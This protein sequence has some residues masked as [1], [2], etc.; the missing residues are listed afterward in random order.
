M[1]L[2][3]FVVIRLV[4]IACSAIHTVLRKNIKRIEYSNT[5]EK[6]KQNTNIQTQN[7]Q[8]RLGTRVAIINKSRFKSCFL[9]FIFFPS[10]CCDVIHIMLDN[11][12]FV[13]AHSVTFRNRNTQYELCFC[14]H[15]VVSEKWKMVF[16]CWTVYQLLLGE[17]NESDIEKLRCAILENCLQEVKPINDSMENERKKR[18]KCTALCQMVE[19]KRR[20]RKNN[21]KRTEFTEAKFFK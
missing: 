9:L 17:V 12:A 14:K 10:F 13:Y 2:L 8:Y 7:I 3:L 1:L 11:R 18:K 4:S 21:Q 19:R 16:E 20:V 15:I 6:K 5:N